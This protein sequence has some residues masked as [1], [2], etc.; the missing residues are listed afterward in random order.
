[1][2]QH[3]NKGSSS[4]NERSLDAIQ[5]AKTSGLPLAVLAPVFFHTIKRNKSQTEHD[6]MNRKPP[7]FQ[8]Y[9]S[10][11]YSGVSDLTDAECGVYIKLLCIE[12]D[13]GPMT[14]RQTR[15]A[16]RDD[17]LIAEVLQAKFEV[18]DDGCW[19]HPRLEEVRRI[20]NLRAE[21]GKRGGESTRRIK[22]KAKAVAKPQAKG[23]A[24]SQAKRQAK[25]SPQSQSQSQEELET[26]KLVSCSEA[27]S[28]LAEHDGPL[29]IDE[30]APGVDAGEPGSEGAIQGTP[31]AASSLGAKP[32]P[33][34]KML[35]PVRGP[36]NSPKE[37]GLSQERID[38]YVSLYPQVPIVS[39]CRK[40][41]Q[42]LI[43]NPTRT[44][45][46]QGMPKFLTGWLC[47]ASDRMASGVNRAELLQA[48]NKK[49]KAM[50]IDQMRFQLI[51]VHGKTSAR[52]WDDARIEKE[53]KA[54]I[55]KSV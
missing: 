3:Q 27:R 15:A 7:A 20:Q 55:V 39:E 19:Y 22:T 14:E 35:F 12:W 26:N 34:P 32:E 17:H 21:A 5:G 4:T 8:F 28:V 53:F 43:D 50:T 23:V 38:E 47:R 36:K 1:M 46:A 16:S 45:T 11:F 48:N 2:S 42:W 52:D 40:A 54:S 31:L 25:R 51:K 30:K 9:A 24:N 37:W 44:K 6:P 49:P 13:K 29:G 41:R 18:D 10:D 33:A